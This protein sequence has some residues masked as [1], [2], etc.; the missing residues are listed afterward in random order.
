[1][2]ADPRVVGGT[3]RCGFWQQTY[4]VRA[5]RII[6]GTRWFTVEWADGQISTHCTN[7]DAKRDTI[8]IEAV[9]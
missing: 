1:M 2:G 7:W 3:Y 4:K 6:E 5:I 8:L 9:S